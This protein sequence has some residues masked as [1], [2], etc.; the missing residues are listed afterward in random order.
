MTELIDIS[1][2]GACENARKIFSQIMIVHLT[3]RRERARETRKDTRECAQL[4][5]WCS[6]Y[7]V[8]FSNVSVTT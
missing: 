8:I 3:L 2:V 1:N 7:R 4:I 6:G 5:V